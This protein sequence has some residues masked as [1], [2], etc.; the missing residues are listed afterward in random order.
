LWKDC[1]DKKYI[2]FIYLFFSDRGIPQLYLR[3][4]QAI[5]ALAIGRYLLADTCFQMIFYRLPGYSRQFPWIYILQ[6]RGQELRANGTYR[7][8][9]AFGYD[10]CLQYRT[11][12]H[13]AILV[14]GF[15]SIKRSEIV[16]NYF[17]N[18]RILDLG[19]CCLEGWSQLIQ[20]F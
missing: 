8:R 5:D 1:L 6:S 14:F 4:I 10:I 11:K 13:M 18:S 20:R 17:R 2:S 3:S 12:S 9:S 7:N 19:S 16:L 15:L